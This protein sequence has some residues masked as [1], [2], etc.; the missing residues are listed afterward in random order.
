MINKQYTHERLLKE[1][2]IAKSA[3]IEHAIPID[4]GH[5]KDNGK[6]RLEL[7]PID[8]LEE[9]GWVMT[10][11]A[12]KYG[13]R[14]WEKGM[15]YSR[16]F[17]A[18]LRHSFA[19]FFGEDRDP[20]SGLLHLAHCGCCVLFLLSYAKRRMTTFDDRVNLQYKHEEKK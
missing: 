10:F 1:A 13:D 4:E 16:L 18:L 9:V 8:A 11:G 5:K 12:E 6:C 7:L 2:G 20:E 14:N 19:W 17:S 3:R 15:K